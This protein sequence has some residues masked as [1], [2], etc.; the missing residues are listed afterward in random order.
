MKMLGFDLTSFFNLEFGLHAESMTA[1]VGDW[2]NFVLHPQINTFLF[3]IKIPH[4]LA[5]IAIFVIL[6]WIFA[7]IS[8]KNS[9]NGKNTSKNS[10]NNWQTNKR[11]ALDNWQANNWQASLV[12]GLWWLNPVNFYAFYIFGRHDAW[13]ALALLAAVIFAAGGRVWQT[14]VT[15]FVGVQVRV[16]PLLLAPLLVVELVKNRGDWQKLVRGVLVAGLVIA[17]YWWG[18]GLLPSN[19]SVLEAH[20]QAGGLS[21]IGDLRQ[22]D[23]FSEAG[24]LR[25]VGIPSQHAAQ[26]MGGN[27]TDIPVFLI[28]YGLI[29]VA[30]WWLGKRLDFFSSLERLAGLMLV[31]MSLYFAL[32]PFFPHY[33]VW[34][35]LPLALY[36]LFLSSENKKHLW[37]TAGLYGLAVIGFFIK[38]LFAMDHF[39]ITQNLFL[40]LSPSLFR[41][42]ELWQVVLA[43]GI[44]PSWLTG[45]G[46]VILSV[47]LI[48]LA[49]KVLRRSWSLLAITLLASM[50]LMG[51]HL[52]APT[53][54]LAF[55]VPVVEVEAREE[56]VLLT[57]HDSIGQSFRSPV[58]EFGSIEIRFDVDRFRWRDTGRVVFRIKELDDTDWWYEAS[59]DLLDFYHQARYPFGF[60][61]ITNALGKD[62]VFELA[63][64]GKFQTTTPHVAVFVR[65]DNFYKDGQLWLDAQPQ[66]SYDMDFVVVATDKQSFW[67]ALTKDIQDRYH[68]QPIFWWSWGVG[69]GLVGMV[70][71]INR[72]VVN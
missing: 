8:M 9:K 55:G 45:L 72:L 50:S 46:Q 3:L 30:F 39:A 26:V 4:L 38:A 10:E 57:E 5:D 18:A 34:L 23:G 20:R 52:L 67:Q 11:Q 56:R 62:F 14:L 35:S 19:P 49:A 12:L 15:I 31:V 53:K 59:Y 47:S 7:K 16:Q 25:L 28:A 44:D 43:R 24:G 33:F 65:G 71:I 40:P 61:P 21:Q 64:E 32:N 60:P 1:S 70:G 17:A 2:L 41:T 42:P 6:A 51:A 48:L 22:A 13:T 58:V 27:W 69:L 66:P 54:T 36:A 37:Q 29:G 63:W 68:A